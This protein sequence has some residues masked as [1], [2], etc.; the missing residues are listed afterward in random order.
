MGHKFG[1]DACWGSVCMLPASRPRAELYQTSPKIGCSSVSSSLGLERTRP[2]LAPGVFLANVAGDRE[3]KTVQNETPTLRA[4]LG[5]AD[6]TS[7]SSRAF[8]CMTFGQVLNSNLGKLPVLGSW[9]I[10]AAAWCSHNM[11]NRMHGRWL[12]GSLSPFENRV[13]KRNM[14]PAKRFVES[15][16]SFAPE[17]YL[18]HA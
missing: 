1:R 10:V 5:T 15:Q 12:A 7:E 6:C 11:Q 8:S 9:S 13:A 14:L 2:W 16:L 17:T 3:R 4:R 18:W